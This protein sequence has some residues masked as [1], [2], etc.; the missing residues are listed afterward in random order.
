ME[1]P[2][3]HLSQLKRGGPLS[4]RERAM[5]PNG[6]QSVSSDLNCSSVQYWPRLHLCLSLPERQHKG[7]LCLSHPCTRSSQQTSEKEV[8]GCILSADDT[9]PAV[10]EF[11]MWK[12][13]KWQD[14]STVSC[15][16][17]PA[18][19]EN[20]YFHSIFINILHQAVA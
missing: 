12:F 8:I 16:W 2:C 7:Q 20:H 1:V 13:Y 19:I 15:F 10:Q 3:V 6:E 4:L 11:L 9:C 17:S 18:G 5:V 14:I